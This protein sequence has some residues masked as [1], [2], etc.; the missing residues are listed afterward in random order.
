M[1]NF[2]GFFN[3]DGATT[4]RVYFHIRTTNSS[5]TIIDPDSAPTWRVYQPTTSSPLLTS[6]TM[7]ARDTG[8]ITGAANNGSGLIRITDAGH[9]L[10]TGDIVTIS[11]VAG[12]TE[13]NADDWKVTVISSST[14]DLQGSTFSSAYV[15]GGTWTLQGLYYG[16]FS[17]TTVLGFESGKTYHI[18]VSYLVS[19]SARGAEFSFTVV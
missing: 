3:L 14:F 7:S 16:L 8:T 2:I 19:S 9:G 4:E 1:S 11:G 12:T 5:G 13:A 6:G 15:S 18:S 10:Q 17:P